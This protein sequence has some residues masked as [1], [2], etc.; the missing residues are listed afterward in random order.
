MKPSSAP[1][2]YARRSPKRV[3]IKGIILCL[4]VNGFVAYQA[5]QQHGTI[6]EH[7]GKMIAIS[8]AVSIA[9][10]IGLAWVLARLAGS[11]KLES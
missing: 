2:V 6:T 1:S 8:V 5:Y 9:L 11:K 10:I 4:A 7:D 3:A